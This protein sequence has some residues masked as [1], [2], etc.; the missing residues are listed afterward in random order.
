[1]SEQVVSLPIKLSQVRQLRLICEVNC[2]CDGDEIRRALEQYVSELFT[3]ENGA[4]AQWHKEAFAQQQEYFAWF[5]SDRSQP[6][7]EALWARQRGD[8]LREGCTTAYITLHDVLFETL[9]LLGR[10]HGMP[11]GYEVESAIDRLIDSEISNDYLAFAER[12][13]DARKRSDAQLAYLL[14]GAGSISN[15]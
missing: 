8:W 11:L 13:H 12:L 6:R 15:H 1:M 3:T 2:T 14:D 10:Y 5:L 7:P 9:E 4:I